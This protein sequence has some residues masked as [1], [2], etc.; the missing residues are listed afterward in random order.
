MTVKMSIF[1]QNSNLTQSKVYYSN[2]T[3]QFRPNWELRS[4]RPILHLTKYSKCCKILMRFFSILTKW[5]S[6]NS[7]NFEFEQTK[8]LLRWCKASVLHLHQFCIS[9]VTLTCFNTSFTYSKNSKRGN[10]FEIFSMKH[11]S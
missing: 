1:Y 6:F 9:S 4:L 3:N 8:S 2:T 11:Y 5:S 7:P 10:K